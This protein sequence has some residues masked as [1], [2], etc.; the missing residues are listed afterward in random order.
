MNS[1]EPTCKI[2]PSTIQSKSVAQNQ[3]F[4]IS[5]SKSV[6]DRR[7][8]LGC[9]DVGGEDAQGGLTGQ[10]QI[11]QFYGGHLLGVLAEDVLRLDVTMRYACNCINLYYVLRATSL[12]FHWFIFHAPKIGNNVLLNHQPGLIRIVAVYKTLLECF[13]VKIKSTFDNNRELIYLCRAR[14]W[15]R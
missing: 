6:T 5:H 13:I 12:N 11:T 3:S 4:K 9:L 2:S 15:A 14:T 8:Q 1:A 10:I 7:L